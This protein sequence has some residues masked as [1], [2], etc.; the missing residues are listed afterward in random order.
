MSANY[1]KDADVDLKFGV[2]FRSILIKRWSR[3]TFYRLGQIV[4]PPIGTGLYYEAIT[5][6]GISGD[7]VPSFP[8]TQNTEFEDGSV[9]WE[10]KHPA[11]V[12]IDAVTSYVFE[13]LDGLTVIQDPDFGNGI[14]GLTMRMVAQGGVPGET[15]PVVVTVTNASGVEYSD[16]IYIQVLADPL[17]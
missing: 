10:G 15:Y 17:A 8:I 12:S 3:G 11:D 5:A 14:D 4:R 6:E 16:T 7:L 1:E 2:E 13:T 9:I